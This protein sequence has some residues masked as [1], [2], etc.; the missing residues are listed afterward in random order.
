[1]IEETVLLIG[2]TNLPTQHGSFL[3]RA[4]RNI[5][6]KHEPVVF[7]A[8][9]IDSDEAP[10]VRIHD[11]CFTSEVFGSL[12]CDCNDQL[13]YAL[14]YIQENSGIIIYLHQEG[15]GI[16]LAN[17]IAAYGLQETGLDTVE[18][19]RRLHLPDD[20]R[21]YTDAAAILRDLDCTKIQL[22]TNN[23]RKIKHLE[24]LGVEVAG[25]IPIVVPSTTESL[26]YLETKISRM[27]HLINP[28]KIRKK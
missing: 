25:R 20:A 28:M 13:V 7:I 22:M 8:G 17:K 11:S 3:V 19:N 9:D 6:T 4:Y 12:K 14:N 21:E 15:R 23:P 26:P 1:M 5:R 27:G 10:V 2:E 18:A 24:K 16:G